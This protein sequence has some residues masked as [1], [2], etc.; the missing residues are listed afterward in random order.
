MLEVEFDKI[1]K[2]YDKTIPIHI[3]NHYINKRRDFIKG[4]LSKGK[5]L[6]VGCG[7]GVLDFQL[8]KLG[9]KVIGLDISKK[10]LEEARRKY[11]LNCICADSITLPFKSNSFDLAISIVALHHLFDKKVIFYSLREML[12]I[13]KPKGTVLIWEHNPLN[14]YWFLFMK[15]LPQ[16]ENVKRLIGLKEIIQDLRNIGINK[17][18]SKRLGFVP[19]FIPRFLLRPFIV[20]EK[21]VESVPLLN[22]L[23]A[24]NVVVAYKG[25]DNVE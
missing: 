6:D 24:H 4:I 2:I 19:D 13:V 22:K 3:L 23:C 25:E 9:L 7:T 12:R 5:V 15:K 20:L 18:V 11:G 21:I 17:I 10:M 8:Y 16:D 1:A 14:P